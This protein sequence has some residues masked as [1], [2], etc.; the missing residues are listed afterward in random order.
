M[1]DPKRATAAGQPAEEFG[2]REEEGDTLFEAEAVRC[3]AELRDVG[4]ALYMHR[5]IENGEMGFTYNGS[6]F[7]GGLRETMRAIDREAKYDDDDHPNRDP[8][9]PG[10]GD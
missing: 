10:D 5:E 1:I 7:Y 4:T 9:G 6:D 3:E 2:G 8:I